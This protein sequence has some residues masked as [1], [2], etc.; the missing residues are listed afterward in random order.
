MK[1]QPAHVELIGYVP[2]NNIILGL[3]RFISRRVYPVEIMRDNGTKFIGGAREL[4]KAILELDQ[5]KIYK[6]LTIKRSNWNFNPSALPWMNV[7]LEA[8]IC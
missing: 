6:K 3:K 7:V 5:N 2:K 1:I 8:I 4:R